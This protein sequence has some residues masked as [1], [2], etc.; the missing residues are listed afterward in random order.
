MVKK[1]YHFIISFFVLISLF[2]VLVAIFMLF[3]FLPNNIKKRQHS[4]IEDMPAAAEEVILSETPDLGME[5]IDKIIFLG[6]ST[7]YG[8]Q[9]YGVLSKGVDTLQVWTGAKTVGGKTVSAGTLSLSP[10]IAQ[11]KIFFP[12]TQSALT[13]SEAIDTKKPEF[14][15]ITLGLNNGA[16]YYSEQ[17]FKECY[18]VLLNSIR[19]YFDST[20]VILQS[21][22][23]VAGSCSI[24]AYTP[25]R[26][27]MCNNWIYDIAKEY[28]IKY[29]N[30]AEVLA[31]DNGYLLDRYENGGDGIHLNRDGLCVVLD[32][33]KKHGY[34]R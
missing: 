5:Y 23:P 8:L 10:S 31:D 30:T 34:M 19:S 24:K 12:D 26:I 32:Y 16:S 29:L 7:T 4:S 9:R 13:I 11:T 6:E 27:E 20:K 22:F 3:S 18:R 1:L 17:E 21:I 25:K 14:L 33:I 28:G 15:I 2:T